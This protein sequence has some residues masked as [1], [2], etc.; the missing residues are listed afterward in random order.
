MKRE[1]TALGASANSAVRPI[2]WLA[3]LSLALAFALAAASTRAADLDSI[4][5]QLASVRAPDVEDVWSPPPL[6]ERPGTLPEERWDAAPRRSL[7]TI[8][9]RDTASR[10]VLGYPLAIDR[11]GGDGP[12]KLELPLHLRVTADFVG[13]VS[14]DR[15]SSGTGI[16][17]R[18]DLHT[19]AWTLEANVGLSRR[20]TK[21]TRIELGWRVVRN[22][23]TFAIYDYDLSIWGI[24][25]RTELY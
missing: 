14:P 25:F 12:F 24:Y 15:Y 19:L 13:S 2:D 1:H 23:S 20:L 5:V 16:A 21:H 9:E 11:P 7:M 4:S 8:A 18:P 22:R 3:M 17:N 6:V 10:G